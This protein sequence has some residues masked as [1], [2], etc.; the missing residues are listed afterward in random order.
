M[1][2]LESLPRFPCGH[3]KRPLT[4][5]GFQDASYE[6][7]AGWPLVGVPTGGFFDVLDVDPKGLSWLR[8]VEPDLPPTRQHVSPRGRH[9]LFRPAGLRSRAGIWPG[10]DVRARGGYVIWWPRQ[11][12]EVIWPEVLA[13]WPEWLLAKFRESR[14]PKGPARVG[15]DPSVKHKGKGL[16]SL[17]PTDFR[18]H[19]AWFSLLVAAKEAGI[20]C[21][22][23]IAWSTSDPA[24]ADAGE[25][26]A[27][28]WASLSA[29]PR[30]AWEPT[31][32]LR[33]RVGGIQ[34]MVRALPFDGDVLF[35]AACMLAEISLR[36]KRIRRVVATD[37]LLSEWGLDISEGQ[38]VI[39]RA[40]DRIAQRLT[41]EGHTK[42]K[43]KA[44][45]C[46]SFS[47][48]DDGDEQTHN[49]RTP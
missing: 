15:F 41:L 18:D 24:Y 22:D 35:R 37:L 9:L 6:D 48:L 31:R 5:H 46:G 23:F 17:D 4:A 40:F 32:N 3:D 42:A 34:A 11:G 27:R 44:H 2:D 10:V 38:A 16:W 19:E 47:A 7:F 13:P 28:R 25:A 30:R 12:Y 26:I 43:G 8:E 36:E 1:F 20:E 14:S 33:V 39:G 21:D 49:E 45:T 29:E